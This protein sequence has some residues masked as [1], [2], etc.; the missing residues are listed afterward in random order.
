MK[1]KVVRRR[2]RIGAVVSLVVLV[3][4]AMTA[5][6]RE[7]LSYVRNLDRSLGDLEQRAALLADSVRAY[8]VA[9]DERTEYTVELQAMRGRPRLPL[10]GAVASGFTNARLHP[11]LKIWRPHRGVDIPARS[12]TRVFPVVAG[13]VVAVERELGFGLVVELQHG[14]V[15]TRYAH[16]RRALV[17]RGD[18]VTPTT[19]I[20]EVGSTG[21]ATSP[22]LHYEI[23][24]GSRQ[25]DPMRW[26]LNQVEIVPTVLRRPAGAPAAFGSSGDP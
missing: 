11:I 20:G 24:A 12:G 13:R 17:R 14:T 1:A 10:M 22:H 16:L 19:P 18:R 5:A 6:G 7:G 26:A 9:L 2:W 4:T 23:L 15:R 21:L 25:V 8:R 3:A